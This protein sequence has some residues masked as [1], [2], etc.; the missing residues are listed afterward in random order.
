MKCPKCKTVELRKSDFNAPHGCNKCGGLWLQQIDKTDWLTED[1]GAGEAGTNPVADVDDATGLCPAG[2]GI[3][4]RAKVAIEQPF[5]LEKCATCGGIWFDKGE[6]L[7]IAESNLA[8]SLT[9]IWSRS[10]QRKQRKEKDRAAFIRLNRNLLGDQIAG[11]IL[12]LAEAL[13]GH[14]E[15]A[16]AIALLQ[17]EMREDDR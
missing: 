13:K 9:D 17:D 10:W 4:I 8:E 3:M 11:L 5:Y 16:R 2:H 6:W 15:K 7:R 14:P 12:Q 1:F